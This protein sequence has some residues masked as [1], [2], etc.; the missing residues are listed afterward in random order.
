MKKIFSFLL[1]GCI[2]FT[3]VLYFILFP[4]PMSMHT[5]LITAAS[6]IISVPL[7]I[8][9][10]EMGHFLAGRLQGMRMLNVSVGPFVIERHEGKLHF[11]I[12]RSVLGYLGRA[13]MGFPEQLETE[14]MCYKLIRYIYGG[15][16]INLLVGALSI[17]IAFA[18]WHYPFFIL[19][20]LM[21]IF[22]GMTNLQPA[23]S[24]SAMT[25]GLVIKRLRTV[26][27]ED[28]VIVAGYSALTEDMKTK[29]VKKWNVDL[30]MQLERLLKCEDST[31]KS[32]LPTIGY[33]YLPEDA[34]KVLDIGRSSAFTRESVSHDYYADC[35]DITFATALFFT[36]KLKDYEEI[37]LELGKIGKT[38]IFMDLKRHALLS[39]IEGDVASAIEHLENAKTAL[40]KWHPLYLRG[41]MERELLQVMIDKMNKNI[42]H[43]FP[44]AHHSND[45]YL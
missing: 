5:L 14:V 15:P 23:M 19:F 7:C 32:F 29:D 34:E 11:H 20:G 9:L 21:N 43:R 28:S 1:G 3:V 25:D 2:G 13:M 27:L 16:L 6:I 39:Y 31:A 26:P 35:A 10:H 22:L 40:G 8:L 45:I 17:G 42:N 37:E 18:I 41:E 38:E 33:Y 24:K 44:S 30:I 4:E 36:E 12:V